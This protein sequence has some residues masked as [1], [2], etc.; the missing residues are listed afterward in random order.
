MGVI[1]LKEKDLAAVGM[2][3]PIERRDY[4]VNQFL[5]SPAVIIGLHLITRAE[6][7]DYV[8]NKQGGAHFD[9]RRTKQREKVLADL[10]DDDQIFVGGLSGIYFEILS[11][12]HELA[13]SPHARTVIS[14]VRGLLKV[15]SDEEN[16]LRFREGFRGA[17]N[18][19]R[20][21]PRPPGED[22]GATTTHLWKKD[23]EPS[24]VA[25]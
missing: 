9:A 11:M 20:M 3:Q 18:S 22:S 16:L 13:L 1:Y 8:A 6:V 24:E 21:S 19:T 23:P 2:D 17:W 15:D 7:I 10:L 12:A 25:G 4:S 5:G 14:Q